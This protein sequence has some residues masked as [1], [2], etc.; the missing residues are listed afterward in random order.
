MFHLHSNRDIQT[1]GTTFQ[2]GQDIVVRAQ[3]IDNGVLLNSQDTNFRAVEDDWPVFAFAQDLGT[4]TSSSSQ[5][6]VFSVGHM[7]DPAVEY[8]IANDQ[9]QPRNSFF[10]SE[11]STPSD[12]VRLHACFRSTAK[13]DCLLDII[14]FG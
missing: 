10:L 9:T 8:I 6:V 7:R 11:F 3:F 14:L 5:P 2:T 13:V 4:V 1:S 12:A